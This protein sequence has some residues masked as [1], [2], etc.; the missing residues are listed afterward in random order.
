MTIGFVFLIIIAIVLAIYWYKS[1]AAS[2]SG[3]DTSGD[4]GPEVVSDAGAATATVSPSQPVDT[5]APGTAPAGTPPTLTGA[6]MS[7]SADASTA[8]VVTPVPLT[9][10]ATATSPPPAAPVATQDSSPGIISSIVA[11]VTGTP[12]TTSTTA[13]S[14]TSVATTSA[15]PVPLTTSATQADVIDVS[16]P[17]AQAPVSTTT[18]PAV[19]T[20]IVNAVTTA[21]T[22]NPSMPT[23]YTKANYKGESW[24]LPD[25]GTF[26]IKLS[27]VG[28]V[29]IPGTWKITAWSA[30]S[31]ASQ[32][33]WTKSKSDPMIT[34][35]KSKVARISAEQPVPKQKKPAPPKKTKAA[36]TPA[37]IVAT[38]VAAVNGVSTPVVT[39]PTGI[40]VT[41][42]PIAIPA[43]VVV[44]PVASTTVAPG[45]EEP[46][47]LFGSITAAVTGAVTTVSDAITGNSSVPVL[48]SKND[49]KG[50]SW[51][52][53]AAGTHTIPAAMAGKVQ[54]YKIPAGWTVTAFGS[55]TGA[56]ADAK[57]GGTALWTGKQGAVNKL[58][59]AKTKVTCIQVTAPAA[60]VPKKKAATTGTK[61]ATSTKTVVATQ[62]DVPIVYLKPNYKGNTVKLQAGVNKMTGKN[63]N[64]IASV[65]V[66]K[67]WTVDMYDSADCTGKALTVTADVDALDKAYKNKVSCVRATAPI[68]ASSVAAANGVTAP[69]EPV[70]TAWPVMYGKANFAGQSYTI[71]ALGKRSLKGTSILNN[72]SSIRVPKGYK[73]WAY[74]KNDCT[75]TP[76]V[77]TADVPSLKGTGLQNDIG[78]VILEQA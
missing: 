57:C 2:D 50:E 69:A 3:D 55:F 27:S 67:G 32:A 15:A 59:G 33:L 10:V 18:A 16:T 28:S 37:P 7:P 29:K 73:L 58:G 74:S 42:T 76:K 43:P 9:S 61:T 24:T 12:A 52:P 26:D 30:Q 14:S 45:A 41:S 17:V 65:K 70:P 13:A 47:T 40:P 38:P 64:N 54:S 20:S 23:F 72:A 78:C 4:S 31:A 66:P 5:G 35:V 71:D 63:D 44:T 25:A 56:A 53:Q 34:G 77:F 11:A 39:T 19:T 1:R 46:T 60:K 8:T 75:G 68:I 51:T 36:A 62:G 21:V 49:F 48:Y 6:S 22:G